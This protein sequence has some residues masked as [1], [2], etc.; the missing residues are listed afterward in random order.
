M[1]ILMLHIGI[2]VND[3]NAKEDNLIHGVETCLENLEGIQRHSRTW[4][5]FLQLTLHLMILKDSRFYKELQFQ[6]LACQINH[7]YFVSITSSTYSS[8]ISS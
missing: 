8:N 3:E 2:S 4:I 1:Q 5:F 7:L 6:S